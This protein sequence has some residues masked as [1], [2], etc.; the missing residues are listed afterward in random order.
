MAL[1]NMMKRL[2]LALLWPVRFAIRYEMRKQ[3][4]K[5]DDLAKKVDA[6]SEVYYRPIVREK[7]LRIAVQRAATNETAKYIIKNMNMADV[8]E[9]KS[10]LLEHA[11]S[12]AAL[13]E[14]DCVLEFGVFKGITIEQIA[15]RFS[16]AIFG[17]DSFEGLPEKWRSGFEKGMFSLPDIPEMPKNVELI[18]GWYKDTLPDFFCKPRGRV[19]FIHVDCDLYSSTKTVFEYLGQHINSGCVLL[20]DEYFNYPGWE[21]G[22]F[23]AFQ[24]FVEQASLKYQ[25]IGYNMRDE[26]VAVRIV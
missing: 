1:K 21:E 13:Q 15:S 26:Q 25:Y 12:A 14:S 17:F 6:V 23:R 2:V 18:K 7:N 10:A 4:Q 19:R 16:G 9:S 20:F 22:E 8:F 11:L 24:E 3:R 5:I